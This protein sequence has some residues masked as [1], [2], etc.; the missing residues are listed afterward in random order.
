MVAGQAISPAAEGVVDVGLALLP[1]EPY[2]GGRGPDAEQ[3]IGDD[4]VS[5]PGAHLPGQQGCLV[6]A[7][8]AL[9]GGVEWDGDDDVWLPTGRGQAGPTLGQQAAQDGGQAAQILVFKFVDGLAQGLAVVGEGPEAVELQRCLPA[10][11]TS[12]RGRLDL[13]QAAARTDG[14]GDDV[15]LVPAGSTQ[16]GAEVQAGY[17]ARRKK[18]VDDSVAYPFK[19]I[20]SSRGV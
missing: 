5:Q 16:P 8:L 10:S 2:L 3:G 6:V 1:A 11:G 19:P 18:E 20:Q 14:G 13:G 7:T 17:T 12:A 9:A 4:G 15:D